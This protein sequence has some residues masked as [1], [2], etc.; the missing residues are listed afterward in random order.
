VDLKMIPVS[1]I[2]PTY[3]ESEN[4]AG[5][6]DDIAQTLEGEEYEI[7]VVDDDS[8]DG[9]SDII[10]EKIISQPHLRLISRTADKGLIPSLREGV[11]SARF[12]LCVWLDADQSMKADTIPKL[13]SQI[14]GGADLAIGSRYI[15][16]GG[17]KGSLDGNN[18][19]I[20]VRKRLKNTEDSFFQVVLSMAGNKM[21]RVLMTSAVTDYTSGYYAVKKEVVNS[22][23]L[24]GTYVD[25]CI[26]FAYGAFVR[27][28]KIREVPLVV[29]PRMQGDSKTASGFFSLI[30]I[31]LEC[32]WTAFVLRMNPP[33]KDL[34]KDE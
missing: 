3:N 16:G 20:P 25:Y 22:V 17:V 13:I 32:L 5:V 29:Y 33:T 7:I 12:D 30:Y 31:A 21:L 23:G 6:I 11:A 24:T 19:L 15:E 27:G 10:R 26:R 9:T 4:I 34:D 8:P 18:A 14:E 2:L 1:I 28:Y